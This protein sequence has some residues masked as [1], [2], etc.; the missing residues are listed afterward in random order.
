MSVTAVCY[1][2]CLMSAVQRWEEWH[3]GFGHPE[4]G[5]PEAGHPEAR[6]GAGREAGSEAGTESGPEG[7]PLPLPPLSHAR[8]GTLL[9][10]WTAPWSF[11][12]EFV[13]G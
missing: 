1:R 2:C 3:N 10:A 8:K 7:R 11:R 6:P 5:H 4:A 13:W 9:A 12:L